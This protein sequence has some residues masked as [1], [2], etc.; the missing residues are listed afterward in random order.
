VSDVKFIVTTEAQLRAIVDD[1]VSA[2]VAKLAPS[3]RPLDVKET[4]DLLGVCT[5]TVLDLV[6]RRSLPARR[7]GKAYRFFR[8]DVLDWLSKQ[9]GK[10][11]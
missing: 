2:A 7:V 9:H 1:A 11:S 5:K 6:S 4:A 8:R 3:E 10:A